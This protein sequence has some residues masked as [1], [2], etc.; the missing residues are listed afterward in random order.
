MGKFLGD[1]WQPQVLLNYSNYLANHILWALTSAF[2]GTRV[3][4]FQT[5]IIVISYEYASGHHE[6]TGGI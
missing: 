5:K 3:P 4:Y 1:P 6:H 2:K